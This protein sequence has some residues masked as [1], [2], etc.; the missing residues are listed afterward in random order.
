MPTR[1]L[2]LGFA[3]L[4][5]GARGA[6]EELAFAVP[7]ATTLERAL[8]SAFTLDLAQMS[9][10]MDGEEIPPEILGEFDVHI[11]HTE[12]Y[13]ITDVFEAVD[14][15]RPTRLLRTFD[16]LGAEERSRTTTE[17]GEQSDDSEYE[18]ALE[19]QSVLFTWDAE[20]EA[21]EV[22]W[23]SGSEG[24]AELLEPLREDLDLRGFLPAEAVAEGESWDVDV[25]AFHAVLEPGGDLALLDPEAEAEPDSS[26]DQALRENL[27]G[28]VRATFA[29]VTEEE[30][31]R[32]ARITL[33]V[34]AQT[35][36]AQPLGSDDLPEGGEGTSR[37]DVEF[38]LQG[39]LAWDL[40]GGHP[41]ALELG[42]Q[43]EVQ[44]VFELRGEYE[45][46]SFEQR[47]TMEFGGE[48]R[49]GLRVMRR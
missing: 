32:L 35:F 17:Q 7:A 21:Y 12:R 48:I 9:L 25:A 2:F 10:S 46:E 45:G 38:R 31:R 43:Y 19:G 16:E 30:G 27:T 3:L 8:E 40:A 33:A 39:E 6:R 23:A 5:L 1:A 37:S 36:A 49:F 26:E 18:S 29:G 11:E 15:A 42:G 41:H 34:E 4:A 44:S 22:D 13:T 24:E 20:A 14:G 47:Q 28:S